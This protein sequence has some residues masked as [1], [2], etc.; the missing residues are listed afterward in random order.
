[1]IDQIN[2]GRIK[3]NPQIICRLHPWSRLELFE[4]YSA[5]PW[6]KISY[7]NTHFP[8]IGWY[9][10]KNDVKEMANMIGHS[11]L[12]ISPGSTVLLESAIFN[13]PTLFPIFHDLQPERTSQY[14]N[15]WVLGKHFD[16][17]KRMDLVP[18]IDKSNNFSSMVNKCL[19]NPN[20]YSEQRHQLVQDYVQFTDGDSTKRLAKAAIDIANSS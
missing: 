14:F 7:I 9:M 20:W 15:R 1:M 19:E 3:G 18:I 13:R 10:N 11:D 16:R 5:I 4:K 8:T 17:I 2:S 6:I 12:V